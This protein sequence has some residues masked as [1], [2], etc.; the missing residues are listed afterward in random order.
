MAPSKHLTAVVAEGGSTVVKEVDVPKLGP[1]QIL[2]KVVAAAQNPTDWKTALWGKRYGSVSGCDFSGVIEELGPDVPASLRSVGDRVAGIVHGGVYPNGAFAEYLVVDAERV[3]HIPDSWSFEDAAQL[4]VGPYTAVQCLYQSHSFATPL[5]PTS[6][7]TPLLI[8]GGATSVGQYVIQFAKLAGLYVIVTV[9]PKNFD[10][11][12]SLGADEVFDY[13]DPEVSKN[14]KLATGGKLAHAV[15][16]ISENDTPRQI[17]E[18]LSDDGGRV[19]A[20]LFYKSPRP[21]V[22]VNL[23]LA[24]D[25]LGKSY[26]FPFPWTPKTDEDRDRGK[27]FT[28]LLQQI[29]DTGKIKPNATLILP[30]GL[31]SVAE[32]FEYQKTG[33]VSAQKITYRIADTPRL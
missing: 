25:L 9:S 8:W 16:T 4:G 13:N 6:T 20:L 5:A 26:D 33:K 21:E 28:Q 11:V 12:K 32:G 1:G 7:P 22:S 31:A 2:V 14:I 18:A 30:Q 10:L 29:I 17:S 3:L 24:Y 19:A 23:T 15:D 27:K